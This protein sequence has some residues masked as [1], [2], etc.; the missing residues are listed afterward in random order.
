ME[1]AQRLYEEA[2]TSTAQALE[3]LVSRNSFGALLARVT[4]NTMALVQISNSALDLV[5]RNLR[6]AGRSDLVRL[7]RQLGRTEDKL[8]LVLQEIERLN[9]RI[10]ALG[11]ARENGRPGDARTTAAPSRGAT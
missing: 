6:V 7:G 8:E 3:E 2:E 11:Q 10:D 9:D 5:V 1:E 4:E